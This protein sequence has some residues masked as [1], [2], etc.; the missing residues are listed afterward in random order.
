M[1]LSNFEQHIDDMIL[2]RGWNYYEHGHIVNIKEM[3]KNHFVIHIIGSNE[4]TVN[5]IITDSDEISLGT[6]INTEKIVEDLKETYYRR[7]AFIDELGKI[8]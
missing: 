1:N 6:E 8:Y 7:T 3:D 5:V 4:Y 2:E